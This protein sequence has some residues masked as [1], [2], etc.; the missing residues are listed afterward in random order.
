[1]KAKRYRSIKGKRYVL[2][3]TSGSRRI[4]E[5]EAKKIRSAG[6]SARIIT[7]SL[8][9]KFRGEPDYSLWEEVDGNEIEG[10]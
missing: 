4:L 9:V 7:G 10:K 5:E 3:N 6:K 1:M 8:P 2:V